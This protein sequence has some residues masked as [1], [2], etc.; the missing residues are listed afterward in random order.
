MSH[1]K[2][3][4]GAEGRGDDFSVRRD[5]NGLEYNEDIGIKIQLLMAAKFLPTNRLRTHEIFA[6]MYYS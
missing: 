3:S 4:H 5:I 2:R 6:S 1:D